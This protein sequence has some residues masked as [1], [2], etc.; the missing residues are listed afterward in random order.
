M[1]LLFLDDLQFFAGK[2]AT[3]VELLYTIDTLLRQGRQLVFAADRPPAEL[4]GLGPE[5]ITRLQSGMV[6]RIEPPDYETRLG[7]VAQMAERLGLRS[8]RKRCSE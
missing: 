8:C 3:Q 1:D 6:C 4:G 7:I 5:L 2:R